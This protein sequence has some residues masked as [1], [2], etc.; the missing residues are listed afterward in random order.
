MVV[1]EASYGKVTGTG[2]NKKR[3]LLRV[4]DFRGRR[5]M[6]RRATTTLQRTTHCSTDTNGLSR[7]WEVFMKNQYLSFRQDTFAMFK[8]ES[9]NLKL[10]I[11]LDNNRHEQ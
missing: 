9:I 5:I 7:V 4:V 8:S 1:R 10:L 2:L 6:S 3:F 11:V